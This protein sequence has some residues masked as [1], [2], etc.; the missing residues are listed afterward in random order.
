MRVYNSFPSLGVDCHFM[1]ES[2]SNIVQIAYLL[3][4]RTTSH[5]MPPHN[6]PTREQGE[7]MNRVSHQH[8]QQTHDMRRSAARLRSVER[9]GARTTAQPLRRGHATGAPVRRSDDTNL[10]RQ[11]AREEEER[12]WN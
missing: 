7:L 1:T 11:L 8:V 9:D 2:S 4:T 5:K 6:L 12:L 10:A 3:Y